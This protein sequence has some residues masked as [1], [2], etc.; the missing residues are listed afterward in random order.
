MSRRISIRLFSNSPPP[1]P[2]PRRRALPA[3]RRSLRRRSV[4]HRL[5]FRARAPAVRKMPAP[6]RKHARGADFATQVELNGRECVDLTPEIRE[7]ILSSCLRIPDVMRMAGPNVPRRSRAPAAPL[8]E[9]AD[10]SAWDALDHS[11]QRNNLTTFQ[12]WESR[13]AKPPRCACA[14]ARPRTAG[15]PRSLPSALSAAPPCSATLPAP[16]AAPTKAASPHLRGRAVK[17]RNLCF[18]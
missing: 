9:D 14:P 16:R 7:D 5:A 8:S 1:A 2:R 12:S 18:S 3:G 17:P 11:N 13:N 6:V 15:T 10:H 4:R